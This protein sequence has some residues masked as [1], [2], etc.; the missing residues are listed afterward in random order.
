MCVP[1]LLRVSFFLISV[2]KLWDMI[3]CL[4]M[5]KGQTHYAEGL[6]SKSGFKMAHTF[7]FC[8]LITA[9]EESKSYISD[10]IY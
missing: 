2:T 4:C 1:I 5:C 6:E 8:L 10:E 3:F 9:K 7:V